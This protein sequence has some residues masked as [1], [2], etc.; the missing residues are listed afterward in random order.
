M[1]CWCAVDVVWCDAVKHWGS[2]GI[3][4]K[5]YNI[6]GFSTTWV[7]SEW[8][9]SGTEWARVQSRPPS[10]TLDYLWSTF[11][12]FCV[13]GWVIGWYWMILDDIGWLAS[14]RGG[15]GMTGSAPGVTFSAFC[16]W[17]ATPMLHYYSMHYAPCILL[18]WDYF[19][20]F[21]TIHDY[22]CLFSTVFD[23]PLTILVL[24]G[25]SIRRLQINHI[26]SSP[27]IKK[28]SFVTSHPRTLHALHPLHP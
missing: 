18:Y 26:P 5:Q 27:S 10:P 11:V 22:S 19:Q 24:Y 16:T 4:S 7:P 20:L 8:D 9:W 17:F 28:T 1:R 12:Y 23:Y 3:A 13:A 15:K 25:G 14:G 21:L 2:V 6:T